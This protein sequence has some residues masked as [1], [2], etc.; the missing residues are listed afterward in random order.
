MVDA[1]RERLRGIL[2]LAERRELVE[3]WP[4]MLATAKAHARDLDRIDGRLG[5][6]ASESEAEELSQEL[7]D[8]DIRLSAFAHTLRTGL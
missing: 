1:E 8:F 2:D 6:L 5:H 7:H 3:G 4:R